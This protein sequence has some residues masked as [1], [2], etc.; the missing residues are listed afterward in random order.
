MQGE[1]PKGWALLD[2][3][4]PWHARLFSYFAAAVVMYGIL[5]ID[6]CGP[7]EVWD[8]RHYDCATNGD[9]IMAAVNGGMSVFVAKQI[10]CKE[11]FP[12]CDSAK[13][14]TIVPK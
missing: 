13:G 14:I 8:Q 10:F 3:P 4:M 9:K 11:I 7:G 5:A 2:T 1:A 6:S 12:P